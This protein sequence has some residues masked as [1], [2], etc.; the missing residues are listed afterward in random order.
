[1]EYTL[2]QDLPAKSCAR[3]RQ[4]AAQAAPSQAVHRNL[5]TG[6]KNKRKQNISTTNGCLSL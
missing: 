5:A 4:L 3:R 6:P 2:F 1:M